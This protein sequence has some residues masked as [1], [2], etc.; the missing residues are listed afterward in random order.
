MLLHKNVSVSCTNLINRTVEIPIEENL[1]LEQIYKVISPS[2][3][4]THNE[5]IFLLFVALLVNVM[6]L[7]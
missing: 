4:V 6:L 1:S 5:T 2:D 3:I 7:V